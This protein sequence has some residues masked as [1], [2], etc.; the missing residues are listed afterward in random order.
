MLYCLLLADATGLD[1]ARI[2]TEKLE[3]NARKYPVE[4]AYGTAKKYTEL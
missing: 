3:A 1:A 4:K 2:M